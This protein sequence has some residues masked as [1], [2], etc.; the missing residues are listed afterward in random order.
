LSTIF[1]AEICTARWRRRKQKALKSRK[2]HHAVKRR[3]PDCLR[4]CVKRLQFKHLLIFVIAKPAL[5][6][7]RVEARRSRREAA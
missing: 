6:W 7:L 2:A 5:G 3:Y 1:E 4:N